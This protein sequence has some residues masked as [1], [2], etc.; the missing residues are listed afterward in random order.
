[1]SVGRARFARI[2]ADEFA[3]A[4]RRHTF[5]RWTSPASRCEDLCTSH[6]PVCGRP[7]CCEAR[8]GRIPRTFRSADSQI[9]HRYRVN[10]DTPPVPL[11]PDL[12]GLKLID[13]AHRVDWSQLFDVPGRPLA[14]RAKRMDGR[15]VGSLIRLPVSLTGSCQIEELHSLA[16]RD[17]ER[18]D[19]VGLPSGEHIAPASASDR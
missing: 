2:A 12:L 3:A 19:G 14:Q 16:V 13:A 17:L 4:M 10:E 15:L 11:F 5:D 8:L 6:S 1:M 9:R 7:P 18:G